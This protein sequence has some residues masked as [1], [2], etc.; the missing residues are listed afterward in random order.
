MHAKSDP[1]V[2]R[3]ASTRRAVIPGI[4]AGGLLLTTAIGPAQAADPW[5][6]ARCKAFMR[7]LAETVENNHVKKIPKSEQFG[8]IYEFVDWAKRGTIPDQWIQGEVHDTMH[9]GAWF[10]SGLCNASRATGDP[11]YRDF[12]TKYPLPFYC[13]M[14]NHSAELFNKTPYLGRYIPQPQRKL[15]KEGKAQPTPQKGWVPYWWDDG[16]SLTRPLDLKLANEKNPHTPWY[17]RLV[18]AYNRLQGVAGKERV[19]DGYA[20]DTSNHM[21]QDLGIMLMNCWWLTRDEQVKLAALAI[22]NREYDNSDYNVT[23][24]SGVLV[25]QLVTDQVKPPPPVTAYDGRSHGDNPYAGFYLGPLSGFPYGGMCVFADNEEFDYYST[26]A[27]QGTFGPD[28]ARRLMDTGME[29]LLC[30][31]LYQDDGPEVPGYAP[32]ESIAGNIRNGK[33]PHYRSK[34]KFG[35]G[36]R[37]ATQSLVVMGRALH[38][39]AKYPGLWEKYRQEKFPQDYHVRMLD[40]GPTIDGVRDEAYGKANCEVGKLS[41]A[42]VS[43]LRNLYVAGSTKE[44]AAEFRVFF[45]PGGQETVNEIQFDKGWQKEPKPV[46]CTYAVV[47]VKADGTVDAVNHLKE[48]LVD[49]Q[50]VCKAAGDGFA[51]E[52]KLP[53]TMSG[54]KQV[55][56][57]NALEN[58]RLS[59]RAGEQTRDLYVQSTEERAVRF[60]CRQIE[61]SFSH[62]K[63]VFDEK[64]HIIDG[65]QGFDWSE[66]GGYAHLLT[67]LSTYLMYLDG[68]CVWEEQVKVVK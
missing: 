35:Q 38:A 57:A 52:V 51:F 9:D 20:L 12:L 22:Q 60:L 49:V 18:A 26:L 17:P 39:F 68:K 66:S 56:W 42:M 7:R 10:M 36:S 31:H 65:N 45:R 8:M 15:I 28:D 61:G 25:G 54:P 23:L 43:D 59:V 16:S 33:N 47:T 6:P 3:H 32:T 37:L 11:Y 19:L 46:P 67:A 53:Y 34:Q 62:W 40:G 64:G 21:A 24:W 63:Q 5:N 14:L 1:S 48:P 55:L 58:T 44:K 13:K 30:I 50:A 27:R 2:I 4:L 41:L 29:I